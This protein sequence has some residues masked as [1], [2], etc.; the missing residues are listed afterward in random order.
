MFRTCCFTDFVAGVSIS[1]TPENPAPIFF[2]LEGACL[3]FLWSLA[4]DFTVILTLAVKVKRFSMEYVFPLRYFI[5]HGRKHHR[6]FT[7]HRLFTVYLQLTYF[8]V[9]C[10]GLK[11]PIWLLSFD[12]QAPGL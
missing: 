11:L 9:Y 8:S 12:H 5:K 4:F 3:L 2:F 6:R 10:V 7:V 1:I